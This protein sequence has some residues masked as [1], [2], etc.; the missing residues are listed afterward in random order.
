MFSISFGLMA[1]MLTSTSELAVA[2]EGTFFG[3]G[4]HHRKE[5][6]VLSSKLVSKKKLK[7]EA[8]GIQQE[9]C[10]DTNQFDGV[11]VYDRFCE[12]TSSAPISSFTCPS[13]SDDDDRKCWCGAYNEGDTKYHCTISGV[14]DDTDCEVLMNSA[15]VKITSTCNDISY[16]IPSEACNDQFHWYFLSEVASKCCKGEPSVCT[17]VPPAGVLTTGARTFNL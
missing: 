9:I 4:A 6:E 11:T 16:G 2:K 13:F 12:I 1:S 15:A 3:E 10:A 14:G 5:Y 17:N 7:L 8:H